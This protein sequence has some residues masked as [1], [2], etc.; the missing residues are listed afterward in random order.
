MNIQEIAERAGVSKGTVSKYL[1]R[2]GYVGK[3][4]A[5]RIQAVVD[6][7]HYA[8]SRLAQALSTGGSLKLVG[9]IC[10][11]VCDLYYAKCASVL[12][13]RLR[14][15]GFE[16]ILSCTGR[17]A[18]AVRSA[19]D[20]LARK[21]VDALI[22]I[23]SVFMEERGVIEDAAK[24]C[25]CFLI[26]A[27]L[28]AENVYSCYCDDGA[29]VQNAAECLL[30]AGRK[31]LL[32]L[33]DAE[34]YGAET[35]IR[36]FLRALPDRGAAVK[37]GGDFSEM[38][39]VLPRILSERKPDAL[40]CSNDLIAAAAVRAAAM[41]GLRIPDDLAVVGHNNSVLSET[42]S[43]TVTSI[44]N[45]VEQLSELT[46]DN[47]VKRFQNQ[48]FDSE[49]RVDAELVRRESFPATSSEQTK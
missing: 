45:R 14:E 30:A 6:E 37:C 32:Y 49:I 33:Y 2:S 46:A 31:Q 1:N 15:A 11:D 20:S 23:G 12:E 5:A 36:G 44:D 16:M 29:A 26:N 25:P 42:C 48:P 18:K 3:A 39:A 40:L 22:F 19:V 9:L 17:S 38:L 43:P 13:R 10:Y 4:T 8:P 24:R 21:N 28:P 7:T 41:L 47:L 27:N 35:K 34:T